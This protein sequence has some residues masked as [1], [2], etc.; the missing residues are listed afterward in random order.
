MRRNYNRPFQV[1]D[2]ATE[3]VLVRHG[4]TARA[5]EGQAFDLVGGHT[6]APLSPRGQDQAREVAAR[7]A[8]ERITCISVT[9][10]SRTAETA[11]PLAQRVGIN[12]LVVGALREVHLGDAETIGLGRL[13]SQDA[14]LAARLFDEQRWDAIPNAESMKAFTGRVSEGISTI[15][16]QAGRG[17]VAVAFLHGGVIAEACRQVTHSDP[18]AFLQ[19][20]N[21]SITRVVCLG[22]GGWVLRSFNDTSHLDASSPH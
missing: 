8:N 10:L 2:D 11:A 3:L 7:L 1:P 5:T 4:S 17:G 14:A 13:L 19:A 12:P 22:D 6:D 18:F 16:R 20:D 21:G 9:T 15:V